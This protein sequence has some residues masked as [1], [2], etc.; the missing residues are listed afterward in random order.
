[1][2]QKEQIFCQQNADL[3]IDMAR[4]SLYNVG[5]HEG[6]CVNCGAI[7]GGCEPDAEE[8]ECYECGESTVYGPE[9]LMC[10]V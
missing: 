3:I 9:T 10:Y 4:D 1:M 6:L 8:Y 2:N 7:R 5:N